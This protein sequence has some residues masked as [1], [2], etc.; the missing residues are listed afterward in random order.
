MA[1]Q[2]C[3]DDYTLFICNIAMVYDDLSISTRVMLL[4]D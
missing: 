3:Q 1:W 2:I 4:D